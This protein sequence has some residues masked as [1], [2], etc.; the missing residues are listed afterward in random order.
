MSKFFNKSILVCTALCG[1]AFFLALSISPQSREPEES[2]KAVAVKPVVVDDATGFD[3]TG[4]SASDELPA[5][6]SSVRDLAVG[7]N[8]PEVVVGHGFVPAVEN[9]NTVDTSEVVVNGVQKIFPSSK[10]DSA[11]SNSLTSQSVSHHS[12]DEI[13]GLEDVDE[14]G[15]DDALIEA[16]RNRDWPVSRRFT[17]ENLRRGKE[18]ALKLAKRHE[19]VM[20][21]NRRKEEERLKQ[22]PP[23]VDPYLELRQ[24]P[25]QALPPD[26]VEHQEERA[27]RLQSYIENAAVSASNR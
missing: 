3:G 26:S 5:A 16:F 10:S 11:N 24:T 9:Q 2:T 6:A 27:A 20:Q 4:S 7:V 14:E 13:L 15:T 18:E 12:Q 22:A 17:P 21:E 8:E 1:V 25:G 23:P 19:E